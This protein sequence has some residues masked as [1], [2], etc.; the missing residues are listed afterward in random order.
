[1]T[2][3]AALRSPLASACALGAGLAWIAWAVINSR[4]HGGLDVGPPAIGEGVARTGALLMVAWNVLLLPAALV[5]HEHLESAAPSR[6]RLVTLAG[7]ASLLFWAFGGATHTITIPLEVSYIALSAVWWGGLGLALRG[8]HR[9]FGTFTLVLAAF[10]LWDAVLTIWAGVPFTLYLT[11]APKLPLSIVWDF[12]LAWLLF[13]PRV[14]A[15]RAL[16]P[17]S[18]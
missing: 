17:Q 8:G 12:W 2:R 6:M 15:E 5:L 14:G 10:A 4:T 1:M 18:I 7:I 13:T 3:P 11:A 16:A 9:W